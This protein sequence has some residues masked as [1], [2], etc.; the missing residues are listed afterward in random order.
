MVLNRPWAVVQWLKKA[1]IPERYVLMSEPDHIWL[2]PMP[3]LMVDFII[4]LDGCG[5]AMKCGNNCPGS[6]RACGAGGPNICAVGTCTP[7]TCAAQ[8][9]DCGLISDGCSKV[10]PCGMCPMGQRCG[11]GGVPNVC[12]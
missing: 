9:K 10:L 7:T 8:G 12:G 2:K 3:N 1:K 6:M 5:G 4:T 11:G